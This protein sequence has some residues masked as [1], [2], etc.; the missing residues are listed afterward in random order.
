MAARHDS[1]QTVC[2]N[3]NVNANNNRFN[4]GHAQAHWTISFKEV[5]RL[6]DLI[7]KMNPDLA[8]PFAVH[9]VLDAR[10]ALGESPV[11]SAAERALYRVDILGACV[12]RWQP[13]TGVQTRWGLPAHV[14][15][16]ALRAGGGIVVALRSGFAMLDTTT[17]AVTPL[18]HPEPEMVNNRLNDGKVSPEGRYWAGTMDDRPEK[19]AVASLYRLDADQRCHRAVTGLKISNGL[20]WSPDGRTMYHSDSRAAM[21]WRYAYDP[22]SGAL[23]EREVFIAYQPEWG[24]PDGAAVDAEG[25]YWSAGVTA[26]RLNRFSPDGVLLGYVPMPVSHPTMP[27]FGG[28]DLKTLYVTSLRAEVPAGMLEHTPLAG[29]VFALQPGVAGA[30]VGV[31]AG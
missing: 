3:P 16:L 19:E 28:P 4:V 11:W 9:C 1:L 30:P 8:L 2:A 7:P 24:R 25:C 12:H 22:A 20:A 31:Y 6:N 29:G 14:G 5:A 13:E 18:L 17:G 15:S 26:G 10:D 23:G 27:C 21:V